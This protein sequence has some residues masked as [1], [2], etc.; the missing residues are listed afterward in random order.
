MPEQGVF[1]KPKLARVARAYVMRPTEG[2]LEMEL[3]DGSPLNHRPGQFVMVSVFGHGEAPISICSSPTHEGSFELCV[4]AV[5]NLSRAVDA[6]C[7][8]DLIGIRGPYGRGFPVLEMK[9]R[10]VLAIAGGIGLAPLRSLIT[11]VL[12]NREDYGRLIIVYGARSPSTLL[13]HDDLEQ[14]SKAPGVE[15][16]VTVDQPDDTWKGRTGVLTLPLREIE[17]NS[18]PGMVVAAVGPPVMYRFVAMELLKRGLSENQIYFSLE[19]Q[20]KCGIGKC[21]HCQLNDVYVCQDGPV[22]RYSDLLGRTEAVE[23]WTPEKDQ[24]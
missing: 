12:D 21:G 18:G 10:D 14:W 17:L 9:G 13:F 15:L 19:R 24:D 22:F 3:Y 11:Y 4:R 1:Y 2:F 16:Y 6:V 8:G 5:G 23:A 20:F 7:A